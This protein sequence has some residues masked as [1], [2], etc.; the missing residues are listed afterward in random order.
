MVDLKCKCTTCKF[1][2][3]CNCKADEI[4]VSHN[5]VCSSFKKTDPTDAEYADEIAQP[6]VRPNTFVNCTANCL[7]SKDGMCIANGITVGDLDNTATCE[8]FLAD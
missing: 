3:N 4:T 2:C 5:T 8:T 1:N 7:F 6:L